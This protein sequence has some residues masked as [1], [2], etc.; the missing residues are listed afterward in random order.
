MM[1]Y[2]VDLERVTTLRGRITDPDDNMVFATLK[3][4]YLINGSEQLMYGDLYGEDGDEGYL[5]YNIPES[6]DGLYLLRA[7]HWFYRPFTRILGLNSSED[8]IH[9]IV[10]EFY[11]GHLN[12]TVTDRNGTPLPGVM[13]NLQG[14]GY[15]Q[16]IT[17]SNGT[18]D[19]LHLP[20][21]EWMITTLFRGYVPANLTVNITGGSSEQILI[22]LIRKGLPATLQGHVYD[23]SGNPLS[24]ARVYF[25]PSSHPGWTSISA[26]TDGTG[27]YNLS[28]K[29][30]PEM[31]SGLT[32]TLEIFL[33]HYRGI[34]TWMIIDE[35]VSVYDWYL[36]PWS[37]NITF[38]VSDNKGNPV[39][40]TL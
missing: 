31:V 32:G 4:S 37:S 5:F 12:I 25:W 18:A 29:N 9:D 40:T 2:D 10:M 17:T 36:E 1:V 11:D 39:S 30:F 38:T 6:D 7:E 22:E 21:G 3:L 16:R 13:V 28:T 8:N 33:S 20:D 35:G 34:E 26:T 15:L 19:F 24:G 23:I 27:F 14:P